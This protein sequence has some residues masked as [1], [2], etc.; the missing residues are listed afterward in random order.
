MNRP[1]RHGIALRCS[2]TE[3]CQLR[4]TYCRDLKGLTEA[5][6]YRPSLTEAELLTLIGSLHATVGILKLRFT[7]GEPLLCRELPS[8]VASCAELGI[9]DL[10]LTTNGQRLA[11]LARTLRCSGLARVNV[12]LDSLDR[13][14][15]SR[16]TRGGDLDETLAGIHAALD[17]GLTPVKLNMVVLRG[18]NDHEVVKMF[19]FALHTGCHVRFL[20][21]MPIGVAASHFEEHYLSTSVVMERLA[22]HYRLEPLPHDLGSTSSDYRVEDSQGRTTVCGFISPTS[23]PF[24]QGCNRLRLTHDGLLFSCL[25]RRTSLD[26]RPALHASL[27]GDPTALA[28]TVADAFEMK[29]ARHC[30]SEQREMAR[31]GG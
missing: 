10:S 7:G 13:T 6:P 26:M 9:A 2:V 8:L 27:A 12:S 19:D 16:I 17:E 5:D 24:C 29:H 4:C 25:A 23:R 30:L 31:I 21:L 11:R 20:E 1:M 18:L 14:I 28:K 22:T 3:A 15:F